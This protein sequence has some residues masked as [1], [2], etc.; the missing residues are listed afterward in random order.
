VARNKRD[1]DRDF[2]KQ[3]HVVIDRVW[4][5]LSATAQRIYPVLLR[6]ADVHHR[7]TDLTQG[8]IGKA[9]NRKRPMKQPQVSRGIKEL[10]GWGVV[11]WKVTPRGRV[12]YLP[13]REEIAAFLDRKE[14]HPKERELS[15]EDIPADFTELQAE[16]WGHRRP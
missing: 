2:G 4:G 12:F 6:C 8:Q 9:V 14:G 3:Y 16:L 15:W 7:C 1:R 5:H 10:M 11:E 13:R